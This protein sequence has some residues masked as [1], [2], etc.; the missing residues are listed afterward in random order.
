MVTVQSINDLHGMLGNLRE[1]DRKFA[2]SLI[3]YFRRNGFVTEKQAPHV[4]RL[5]DIARG[6]SVKAAKPAKI[7]LTRIHGIMSHAAAH[8]VKRVRIVL[9]TET[10][11]RVLLRYSRNKSMVYI[12]SLDY[13]DT[14]NHE[15]KARYYG[16]I[17]ESGLWLQSLKAID[18]PHVGAKLGAFNVDPHKAGAVEGHATG[19]CCF[20]SRYLTTAASVKAGYGPICA[21]RFGLPWGEGSNTRNV[22][23]RVSTYAPIDDGESEND[24]EEEKE[25]VTLFRKKLLT[26][27]G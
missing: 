21:E 17:D 5:L 2:A 16:K 24:A 19:A 14:W 13:S 15:T 12:T 9:T 10:G 11:E 26:R 23:E 7:M 6:D 8:D 18:A 1:S 3:G 20:C 25:S 4:L 27:L 22:F